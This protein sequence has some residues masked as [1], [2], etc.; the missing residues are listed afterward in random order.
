MFVGKELFIVFLNSPFGLP[1]GTVVKNPHDDAGEMGDVG[2]IPGSRI[3]PR[4]GNGNPLLYSRLE[5]SVD[6]EV[7]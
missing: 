1:G 4:V 5:N 2:L 6:R 7:W 3:S